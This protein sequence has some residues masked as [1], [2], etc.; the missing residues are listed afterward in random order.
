MKVRFYKDP[1]T[2]LAHVLGHQIHEREVEEVLRG[3]GE[4]RQGRDGSRV[5]IGRTN[6]GRYIRV[7]YVQDRDPESVFVVTAMELVGKPLA[8]Y[9]KRMRRR[10]K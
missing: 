5:R 3:Q 2:A 6:S 8:A 7:I 10:L 9:R 1:D 4:D